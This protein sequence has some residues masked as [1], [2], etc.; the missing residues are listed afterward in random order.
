MSSRRRRRRRC[1]APSTWP[2]APRRRVRRARPDRV[3]A[4][5]GGQLEAMAVRIVMA[6]LA[7]ALMLAPPAAAQTTGRTETAARD[8]ADALRRAPVYVDPA[9]RSVLGP[10]EQRRVENAITR[11]DAGP[12]YVAVFPAEVARGA[13]GS[14]AGVG[15]LLEAA[16]R[17][18]GIYAVVAGRDF[19]AGQLGAQLPPGEPGRLAREAI[20]GHRTLAPILTGFAQRVGR[21]R[22][23]V[24]GQA[25]PGGGGG[26]SGG[27]DGGGA[28]GSGLLVV[29][30]VLGAGGGGLLLLARR[31]RR[32][33]EAAK[34]A[35]LREA[36]RDDLVALGDD[37][38]EIDIP[39]EQ[40]DADPRAREALGVALERYEQAERA[41][42]EARRPE[43]FGPIAEALEEGR[44]QMEVARAHLEG[45]RPPERRPPCFFDPRHGPSARDVLWAPPGGQPRPVPAC[46]ADARR[47]EQGVEPRARE[48]LVG[49]QAMPYYQ[50]PAYFGPWAGGFFGGVGGGLLPGMLLGTMLGGALFG[51]AGA[52]GGAR[53]WGGGGGGGGGGWGGGGRGGDGGD[54]WGGGD[55]GGG[56]AG[57]GDMG[58][59]DFGGGDF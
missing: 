7:G 28:G 38:R 43:D 57:G 14:A 6:V 17:R 10:G 37:V 36:A 48:V 24:D 22:A 12:M 58:G 1:A 32:R 34:V 18:P 29:L 44:Y 41:L 33:E 19:E 52:V 59:G 2:W 56:D 16:L 35:D 23:A 40:R 25:G 53:D 26:G 54:D 21:A 15:R 4:V 5:P 3:R 9:A 20:D 39:I 45:R 55:W 50:A 46:E 31:R 49:G 11:A 42:D 47:V 27:G 8:A 13:G 30:A 51:P